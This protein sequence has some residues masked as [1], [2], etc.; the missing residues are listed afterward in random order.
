M[1]CA[2]TCQSIALCRL[3]ANDN[4]LSSET[5]MTGISSAC[6]K[7]IHNSSI[8]HEL[9]KLE[10]GLG[11]MDVSAADAK[12]AGELLVDRPLRCAV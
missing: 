2:T 6:V 8:G 4:E 11:D 5:R 9:A 1:R 10:G 7:M 12:V 3:N